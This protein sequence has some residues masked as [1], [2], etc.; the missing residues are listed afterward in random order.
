MWQTA[1]VH[2]QS[3]RA[4]EEWY[5]RTSWV[6]VWLTEWSMMHDN[7]KMGAWF[8]EVLVLSNIREIFI[9]LQCQNI[10]TL[11]CQHSC[12]QIIMFL[13]ASDPDRYLVA[14]IW[15]LDPSKKHLLV[16]CNIKF[17]ASASGND[18]RDNV[19][20]TL[21]YIHTECSQRFVVATA[22]MKWNSWCWFWSET[23]ADVVRRLSQTVWMF[24]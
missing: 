17:I 19:A 24:N 1:T 6:W 20:T 10:H 9:L 18:L 14:F 22:I 4:Y 7:R 23:R 3:T 2:R 21:K 12:D 16:I 13:S 11:Y 15:W 5:N 8:S